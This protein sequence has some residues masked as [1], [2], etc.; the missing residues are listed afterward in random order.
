M[1]TNQFIARQRGEMKLPNKLK[2]F[3]KLKTGN[4]TRQLKSCELG[5]PTYI[6]DRNVPGY[7]LTQV[8]HHSLTLKFCEMSKRRT[9]LTDPFLE[10]VTACDR[11]NQ[12]TRIRDEALRSF[13]QSKATPD[14]QE[15]NLDF[16]FQNC[17]S[18]T[19]N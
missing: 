10:T 1:V 16:V 14:D 3:Q 19:N 5:G 13:R 15:F 4:T 8:I 12:I 9:P 6:T 11:M 18:K 7:I 2:S 17:P